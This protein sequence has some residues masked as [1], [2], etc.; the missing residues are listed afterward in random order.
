MIA[1][2]IRD[3]RY[4][5]HMV[6][7]KKVYKAFD[8]RHQVDVDRSEW[9]VVRNTHEGI[10]TQEEFDRANANMWTVKQ[11][12]KE[13]PASKKN[14][15]VIV[16][17]YCGL[18]LRPENRPDSFMHCPTGRHHRD[19]VCSKVRIRRNVAEDT[20]VRLVRQQAEMLVQAE[21]L[22]KKRK[23][24]YAEK[25]FINMNI[26][27]AEIKKLEE[28]K[29]ADYECYKSGEISRE[30]FIERKQKLD[31]R[32]SELQSTLSGLQTQE[33]VCD[34]SQNEYG[35]ALEI[36]KYLHLESFDKMVMASLIVSAK[37]M[38]EDSLELEWKHHDIYEK[39]FADLA[40]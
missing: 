38:G 6:S 25:P 31:A 19:S 18:R 32:R 27:K 28:G 21:E 12:K 7:R 2:I 8:S 9:I 24:P 39:I 37:V 3:E 15:S 26:I 17:P 33:L 14:F 16:C 23:N 36:K 34:M 22:L 13:K 5:G 4:A 35:E 10:V 1:K 30:S 11:G 29:I 40:K 20:L